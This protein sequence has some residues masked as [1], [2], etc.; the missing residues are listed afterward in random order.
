M[1]CA[2]GSVGCQLVRHDQKPSLTLFAPN[3]DANCDIL[4]AEQVLPRELDKVVTPMY[5]IE[6]PDIL[7]ID[8]Q[9]HVAPERHSLQPGDVVSLNVSGTFPE[10]PIRGEYQVELGGAIS[11]GFSY[12]SVEVVGQSVDQAIALIE[13]HLKQQLREPIVSLTLLGVSGTQRITGDHLVGPDGSV[14]LGQ[15]GSVRLAGMTLE[16]AR[17]AIAEKLSEEFVDPKVSVS[18][19]AYNSKAIY[20]ITQG[21]GLGDNLVRLPFT[22]NETVIDALSQING[23]S[24]VSSSRMWVARPNRD[25]G[26]DL[27][28]PVDWE[29]ITQRADVS[30]NYQLL[31]GDRVFVAHSKLVAFD[32]A[33]AKLTSPLE[34]VLGFT[35]LGTGTASRLSGK[36]LEKTNGAGFSR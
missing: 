36:V 27:L 25:P 10:E 8:V 33:I 11:L 30:T 21:G 18:V 19:Y 29:G 23:L 35:L 1:A 5:R 31:P 28:L 9:Q 24:Y 12:G 20:I 16:E 4:F 13:M 17:I 32:S 26:S 2:L 7:S 14:T 6:P 3:K 15:Y 34:R 22:G